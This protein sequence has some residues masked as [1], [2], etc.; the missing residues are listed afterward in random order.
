VSGSEIIT[1]CPVCGDSVKNPHKGHLYIENEPPFR[2]HCQR[3]KFSSVLNSNFLRELKV[4]DNELKVF[5]NK[6]S[7]QYRYQNN[8]STRKINKIGF[9]TDSHKIPILNWTSNHEKKLDYLNDRLGIDIKLNQTKDYKIILDLKEFIKVNKINIL[10]NKDILPDLQ[11]DFIGFLSYDENYIVFRNTNK[12]NNL[13]RYF[14]YNIYDKYDNTN[15][16]YVI[17]NKI[18]VL[19]ESINIKITEGVIDLYGVYFNLFN[20]KSDGRTLYISANG[21]GYG[22]VLKY[23]AKLGF[24]DM[25]IEF[26]ADSEVD[27]SYFKYIKRNTE[28]LKDNRI[29][30]LYNKKDEDFGV[31][32]ENI[33]TKFNYI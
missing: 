5:V 32:K 26:Y 28:F 2:V 11:K 23:I 9:Q 31:K 1:R 3:C 15:K 18:D 30:I 13:D 14:I 6:K 24:L 8:I 4:H 10:N 29:K 33:E 19:S 25:N 22:F 20:Q 7:K 21:K 27:I 17:P 16:F 12:N